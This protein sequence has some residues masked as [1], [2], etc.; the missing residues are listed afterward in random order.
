MDGKHLVTQN[1]YR[2][3]SGD[4]HVFLI[5]QPEGIAAIDAGFPGTWALVQQALADLGRQPQDVRD[6]LV[7]HCHPDHAGGLAEMKQATGAKVWM[8]T[9]DA[10]M[11]EQGKAFRSWKAAPG[12]GNWWF[13]YRVVRNS[14]QHVE[15]VK[16]EN[17]VGP[18]D[19]IP[20][21]G[22][23]KAIHTPGHS[24][25]HLV[26]LWAGDGGVLFT[27][28]AVNNV[29]ELSGPPIYEDGK[30]TADSLRRLASEKFQVAC[31]GHGEPIVGDADAQFR[32]QWG[33]EQR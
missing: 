10:D 4:M 12:F 15:P 16:V 20:L 7:T 26:F 13:G 31:F 11:L 32:A 5:V 30:L 9:A 17:R 28:D 8:H 21:A 29:A 1:V 27:G 3:D 14:P 25:G 19:V 6:I 33:A 22:G 2:V 23:I 24:A 18:G